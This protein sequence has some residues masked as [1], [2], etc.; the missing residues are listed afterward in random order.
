M[1]VDPRKVNLAEADIEQYLWENPHLV[2]LHRMPIERW[3]KRQFR[4]PSGI[5]D[6]MGV[7][8]MGSLAVVEIKN[9]ELKLEHIA[10]V[11]R[12]AYDIDTVLTIYGAYERLCTPILIGRSVTDSLYRDCEACGVHVQV[13]DV[14]FKLTVRSMGWGQEFYEEREQQHMQLGDDEDIAEY[15]AMV[16]EQQRKLEEAIQA[17][18]TNSASSHANG[19]GI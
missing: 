9:T 5:L 17:L 6:L 16:K 19:D 18:S 12:Y 8:S 13:F 2:Q 3:I 15:V 1:E 7:N 11:K 10:Q 4:I 14:S